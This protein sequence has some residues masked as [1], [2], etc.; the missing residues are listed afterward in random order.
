[1]TDALTSTADRTVIGVIANCSLLV[2]MSISQKGLRRCLTHTISTLAPARA[3]AKCQ[4]HPQRLS[5]SAL[6]PCLVKAVPRARSPSLFRYLGTVLFPTLA[7]RHSTIRALRSRFHRSCYFELKPVG[8]ISNSLA[9]VS[10]SYGSRLVLS[11]DPSCIDR[12]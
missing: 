6:T 11:A 1:M 9:C 2:R 12:K 10:L 8:R 4:L 5:V 7:L 3:I